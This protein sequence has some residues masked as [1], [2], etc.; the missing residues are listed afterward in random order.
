V[1]DRADASRIAR[2][3]LVPG[4]ILVVVSGAAIGWMGRWPLLTETGRPSWLLASL[5]LL[6]LPIGLLPT[7]LVPQRAHRQAVLSAALQAGRRTPELDAALRS[8]IVIRVR[9]LELGVVAA[10]FV[11][12]VLKPF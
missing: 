2:R 3:Q 8:T 6:V 9:M 10:V 4:S 7:V 5:M 11:L 1:G 12:M